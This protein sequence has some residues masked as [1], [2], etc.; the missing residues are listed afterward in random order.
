M[1]NI[2][3]YIIAFVVVI[4]ALGYFIGTSLTGEKIYYKEV[5]EL[6]QNPGT[7]EQK[8]LRVSGDVVDGHFAVDKMARMA[9][10]NVGDKA[11]SKMSVVYSGSIP[12]ALEIGASV[13]LE[14][15]YNPANNTF[16]ANKLLTKCPSKYEAEG[17]EHPEAI[18]KQSEETLES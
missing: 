17:S 3:K 4:G 8:G 10:F 6:L 18:P 7:V 1:S 12:D 2:V 11:G 15:S 13:I 5:A 9:E 16:I 14:G